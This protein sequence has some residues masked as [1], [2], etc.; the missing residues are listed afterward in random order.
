MAKAP[1]NDGVCS[2][3]KGRCKMK[4]GYA[5]TGSFC[6]VHRSLSVL[7]KLALSNEMIPIISETV[8]HTDTRFGKAE[9]T[10]M[11]LTEICGSPPISSIKAAEPLGPRTPLDALIIC[12]CTGNTLAKLS[13]GITDTAVTMAAKAHLRC[14]RPLI[15]ALSTNDALSQNLKNIAVLLSRK[16]VYFVPFGQDDPQGKPHSL[17][18]D[19]SLIEETLTSALNG[20]QLQ[21]L[22]I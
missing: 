18:S 6:T 11:A 3:R 4:I 1:R 5:L 17:I 2:V 22:L 9:D 8:L 19:F 7:K 14:D 20:K 10:V 21:P 15:I 12:P 13:G 16:S